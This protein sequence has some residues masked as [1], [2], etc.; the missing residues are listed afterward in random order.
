MDVIFIPIL[1][2][3]LTIALIFIFIKL[4]KIFIQ[5]LFKGQK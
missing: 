3:V 4:C 2:F 1:S 5:K